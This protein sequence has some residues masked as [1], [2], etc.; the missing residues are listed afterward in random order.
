M[1]FN[2]SRAVFSCAPAIE[3]RKSSSPFIDDLSNVL[4]G[5]H[6]NTAEIGPTQLQ[7]LKELKRYAIE[8]ALLAT[9]G[10][11]MEAARLLDVNYSSFKRMLEKYGR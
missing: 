3:N 1:S 8:Q 9:D 6:T 7:T 10:K 4:S 2:R 5:T 11:K